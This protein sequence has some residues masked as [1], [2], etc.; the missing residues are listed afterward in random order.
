[1][2][3][4]PLH[5]HFLSIC[6]RPTQC[7]QPTYLFIYFCY[8]YSGNQPLPAVGTVP[9]WPCRALQPTP[10]P[11]QASALHTHCLTVCLTLSFALLWGGGRASK[12]FT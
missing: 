8:H 2:Q 10:W 11:G 4:P 5:T 6:T 3:I 1:M 7:T 12:K 9:G